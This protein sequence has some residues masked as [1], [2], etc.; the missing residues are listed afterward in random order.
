MMA[1]IPSKDYEVYPPS[2][3]SDIIRRLPH[4]F[5]VP[6]DRLNDEMDAEIDRFVRSDDAHGLYNAF[7]TDR[8]GE[9]A[10]MLCFS[11][12][13]TAFQAKIRFG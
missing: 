11:D 1:C 4:Y 13:N 6:F 12:E 8:D 3:F 10:W 7:L 5:Y 2:K 9:R